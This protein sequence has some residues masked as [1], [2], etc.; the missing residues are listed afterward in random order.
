MAYRRKVL[1]QWKNL[2]E[3]IEKMMTISNLSTPCFILKEEELKKSIYGFK[4]ALDTKFPNSI[5]G[6]SVK[7]NS[8]PYCL[9]I[10]KDN[11]CYAEV[12]SYHEYRLA[13]TCGFP[14]NHIIY[15]GP[16]KSKDTFLDVL[17]HKGIVNIESFRE[18]EWLRELSCNEI[19]KVG[20]RLNIDISK[21]S[22]LDEN[23]KEDDSRFGFSADSADFKNAIQQISEYSNVRLVG[24]H[25]HRTSKTRSVDFYKNTLTYAL[26][27]I[28]KYNLNIEYI[29]L[30]GGYFGEMPGKPTYADYV[31]AFYDVLKHSNNNYKIIVE[32]GNAIV[33]SAFDY[34]CTVIDV[35][36]HNDKNVVTTDGTRND[37]DPLFHKT[38]YFK[39]F[40][41]KK[42][43]EKCQYKQLVGGLTCLETDRLFVLEKGETTLCLGDK[44]VFNRV[45][46]YTLC[47]TPLFIHYF[48]V[49][50]V[51]R[52]DEYCVVRE[53]WTEKDFIMKSKY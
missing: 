24:L 48:P 10:A 27:V 30:G 6:Y 37:I 41:Y 2:M 1:L 32:P 40:I 51:K 50:Y 5:I 46:A 36:H 25:I 44:I 43:S 26:S 17:K 53:E 29:D 52:G 28:N 19:Y 16:M 14:K 7:T 42:S 3:V 20:I 9:K 8:L 38:D 4:T 23:H 45:G 15:N 33:A 21:I 34:V 13:L 31:D 49:I 11:G 47:L 12:V 35:K 39:S 22:P 18:I